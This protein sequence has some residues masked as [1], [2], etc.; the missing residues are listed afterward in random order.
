MLKGT[1]RKLLNTANTLG[2]SRETINWVERRTYV[3][4]FLSG[5]GSGH[6]GEADL[7]DTGHKTCGSFSAGRVLR[8]SAF[9]SFGIISASPFRRWTGRQA[10]RP[11]GWYGMIALIPS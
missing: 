3:P 11:D 9:G 5:S 1:K 8:Y 10:G 6:K 4:P 2:M 7:N